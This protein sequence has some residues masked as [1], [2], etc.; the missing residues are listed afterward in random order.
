MR[1]GKYE[2]RVYY[3][4]IL[5]DQDYS[6]IQRATASGICGVIELCANKK[7][8]GQGYIKQESIPWSDFLD[9]SYGEIFKE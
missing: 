7:I 6:A 3:K 8:Q 5:G 2:E 9:T 4:K 1:Q